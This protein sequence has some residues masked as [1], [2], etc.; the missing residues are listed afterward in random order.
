MPP[1]NG[2]MEKRGGALIDVDRDAL[3]K[4]MKA[5]FNRQ[6]DWQQYGV[7]ARALTAKQARF[8]PTEAREKALAAETFSEDRIV[9]YACGLLEPRWCYYIASDRCE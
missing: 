9:R 8:D 6:Y 4:R 3:A 1:T 7:V 5:Y 2:L